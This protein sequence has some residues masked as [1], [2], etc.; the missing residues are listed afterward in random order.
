MIDFLS[1]PGAAM[2]RC[3]REWLRD[4][5]A[6]C[7]GGVIVNI[8]VLWG[9][10]LCCLRA[11]ARRSRLIGV[12]LD[13]QRLKCDTAA[14]LW[15]GDSREI[16]ERCNVP[17]SLLF[18]DGDHCREGVAADIAGWV[19]KVQIGG[20]VAFHDYNPSAYDLSLRPELAGVRQAVDDWF[21]SVADQWQEIAAPGSLYALRYVGRVAVA[22]TPNEES[23]GE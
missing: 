18:V 21:V 17:V 6:E 23:D 13:C 4:T 16:H 12:D 15:E 10:S 14:E 1:V 20:I 2:L 22:G 3:E 9:A 7:D 8:G 11:G 19:P 5:A